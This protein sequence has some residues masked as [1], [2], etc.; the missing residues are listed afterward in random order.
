MISLLREFSD[1]AEEV[2]QLAAPERTTRGGRASRG[3]RGG[4]A[5]MREVPV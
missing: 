2:Q 4:D 1:N 3:T 5:F